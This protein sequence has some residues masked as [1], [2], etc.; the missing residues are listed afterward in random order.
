DERIPP[1]HLPAAL[2][3]LAHVALLLVAATGAVR[4]YDGRPRHYF[5]ELPL[6]V[7]VYLRTTL[8]GLD[9]EATLRHFTGTQWPLPV[10]L[11]LAAP[12]ARTAHT[13]APTRRRAPVSTSAAHDRRRRGAPAELSMADSAFPPLHFVNAVERGP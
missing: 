6:R 9:G 1:R 3:G 4:V 13:P 11:A 12:A 7:Y 10:E 8:G 5:T 2:S